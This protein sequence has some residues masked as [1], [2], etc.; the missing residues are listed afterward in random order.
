MQGRTI[1]W[2]ILFVLGGLFLVMRAMSGALQRS[3][4]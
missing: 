1:V 4:P 2:T 3:N